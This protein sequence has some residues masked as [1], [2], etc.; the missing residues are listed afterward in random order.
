MDLCGF[1]ADW[2]VSATAS[3]TAPPPRTGAREVQAD[4]EQAGRGQRA[5]IDGVTA[6]R[7]DQIE[8]EGDS[9]K[10]GS[11]YREH[12]CLQGLE[13]LTGNDRFPRYRAANHSARL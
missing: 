8:D 4:A 5:R 13:L 3:W 2:A 1:P 7:A 6:S 11:D 9:K 12:T 10:D